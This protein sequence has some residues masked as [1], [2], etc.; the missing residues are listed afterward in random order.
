MVDQKAE[1]AS[2]AAPAVLDLVDIELA[3]VEDLTQ[4]RMRPHL[5]PYR[6]YIYVG[7]CSLDGDARRETGNAV[8]I[9]PITRAVS[10]SRLELRVNV[11]SH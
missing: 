11:F 7:E 10:S 6:R 8:S 3:Q 1:Q 9:I 4:M 2:T 5:L